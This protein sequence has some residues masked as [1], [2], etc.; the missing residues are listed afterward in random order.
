MLT[1]LLAFIYKELLFVFLCGVVFNTLYIIYIII[2][3]FDELW[4]KNPLK[5]RAVGA[6]RGFYPILEMSQI[7][8]FRQKPV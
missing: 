2:A 6:Y 5:P 4:G 7:T 3:V 1:L 8:V